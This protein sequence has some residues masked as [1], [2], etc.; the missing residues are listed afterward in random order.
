MFKLYDDLRAEKQTSAAL[1]QEMAAERRAGVC[2]IAKIAELQEELATEQR[3]RE[4]SA[5]ELTAYRRGVDYLIEENRE[6]MDTGRELRA[7]IQELENDRAQDEIVLQ[8][9]AVDNRHQADTIR[10]QMDLVEVVR[11]S[12]H[13]AFVALDLATEELECQRVLNRREAVEE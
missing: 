7:R 4:E 13:A 8:R 11:R 2:N 5:Q 12:E 6:L 10:H 3:L 9:L 1:R